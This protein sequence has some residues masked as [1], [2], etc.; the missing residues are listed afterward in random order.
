MEDF[1]ESIRIMLVVYGLA[2]FI[3]MLMAA[4]IKLIFAGIRRHKA[5]TTA[6]AGAPATVTSKPETSEPGKAD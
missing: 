1:Y 3:S 6:K 5:S 4:I 2:A